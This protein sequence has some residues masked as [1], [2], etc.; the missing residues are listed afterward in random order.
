M[1][2]SAKYP[3]TCKKCGGKIAVGEKIEWSAGQGS[4]HAEC[5]AKTVAAPPAPA[6]GVSI[7][8]VKLFKMFSVASAHLK[9]PK[10]HIASTSEPLMMYVAGEKS[11]H[12]GTLQ[13]IRKA[14]KVWLGRVLLNGEIQ[15][16]RAITDTEKGALVKLL[17]DFA[18]NPAEYAKLHGIQTGACCFCG[19][20]LE[21]YRSVS[22]GYGPICAD[23]FGLPWGDVDKEALQA[24]LDY[25][26]DQA[27]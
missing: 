17:T 20:G 21:D 8:P 25:I 13:I 3:G 19:R 9:Y 11:A 4:Q 16:S 22:M 2:I 23:H 26:M 6:K 24:N 18:T 27:A 10:V 12:K 15:L 14:D 1:T 5:P 7:N